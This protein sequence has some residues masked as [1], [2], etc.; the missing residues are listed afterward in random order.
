MT[1]RAH[2]CLGTDV[3]TRFWNQR[4]SVTS[5]SNFNQC[6]GA[7]G[8]VSGLLPHT[9][10]HDLLCMCATKSSVM[11]HECFGATTHPQDHHSTAERCVVATTHITQS[12]ISSH[13]KIWTWTFP[14]FL[15]HWPR[16]RHRSQVQTNPGGYI[17]SIPGTTQTSVKGVFATGDVRDKKPAVY[18]CA[19]AY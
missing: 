18:N 3:E 9:K 16:T 6:I 17:L 10:T 4:H 13:R 1:I 14:D 15:L 12:R 5:S 11:R 2:K 7:W 8:I 19:W